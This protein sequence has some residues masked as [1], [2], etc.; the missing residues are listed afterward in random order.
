MILTGSDMLNCHYNFFVKAGTF[1][2]GVVTKVECYALGS[3][4]M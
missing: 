2:S 1:C 3:C 4:Q